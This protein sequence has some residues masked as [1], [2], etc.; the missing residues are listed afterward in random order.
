MLGWTIKKR[1]ND[2]TRVPNE[3]EEEDLHQIKGTAEN[4]SQNEEFGG[5]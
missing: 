2:T 5:N 3:L 1:V 4:G